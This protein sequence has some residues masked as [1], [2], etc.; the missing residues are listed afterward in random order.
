MPFRD[1]SAMYVITKQAAG[2]CDSSH[3]IRYTPLLS[4]SDMHVFVIVWQFSQIWKMWLQTDTLSWKQYYLAPT[5]H[6][7]IVKM[8]ITVSVLVVS[9]VQT[10][11][12]SFFGPAPV[13]VWRFSRNFFLKSRISRNSIESWHA[14]FPSTYSSPLHVLAHSRWVKSLDVRSRWLVKPATRSN[15]DGYKK[16]CWLSLSEA[17]TAA[18]QCLEFQIS[19]LLTEKADRWQDR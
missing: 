18:T 13:R 6:A 11:I 7:G 4:E 16:L 9:R 5:L 3:H 10:G 8:H 1:L 12:G 17:A 19:W 2:I 14:S 15:I